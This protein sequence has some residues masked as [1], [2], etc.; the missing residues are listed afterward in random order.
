MN[1]FY[2]YDI[3]VES[4]L[5]MQKDQIGRDR[6]GYLNVAMEA[7]ANPQAQS[8]LVNKLYKDVQKIE[9]IDFGKIPD[10]KG[11]ITKYNYYDQM[12]DCI[13]LLNELMKDSPSNNLILMNKLHQILLNARNDFVFGFKANNFLIISTYNAMVANLHEMINICIVDVTE[14][15]RASLEMK[16]DRNVIR[17]AR[18]AANNVSAFIRYYESGQWNT[19]IKFMRTAT[20]TKAFEAVTMDISTE[21]END[22][23]SG[24]NS[25]AD[26]LNLITSAGTAVTKVV[27]NVVGL[28][29]SVLKNPVKS[30]TAIPTIGGKVGAV[31]G[32][33]IGLLLILRACTKYL[34][35]GAANLSKSL[36]AQAEIL[37]TASENDTS[38]TTG[39]KFR[40]KIMNTMTKIS[41]VIDYKLLKLEKE[42][43]QDIQQS[44]RSDFSRKEMDAIGNSQYSLV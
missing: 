21:A 35:L 11:D 32:A 20:G 36:R 37:R 43:S 27:G 29:G 22:V 12:Y 13:E 28:A 40:T 3:I 10:S 44:N 25:A 8:I 2:S 39:V 19:L 30:F 1:E 5:E 4:F 7:V 18:I 23:L 33:L 17:K 6:M 16:K 24:S 31:I 15:L 26:I 42:V 41:D 34:Y 38:E 9:S 14:Y